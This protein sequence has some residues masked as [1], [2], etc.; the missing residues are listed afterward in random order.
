MKK[1]NFLI[2]WSLLILAFLTVGYIV[3][4][5]AGL[6][7]GSLFGIGVADDGTHLAQ[8]VIY[9]VFGSV[10]VTS[11]SLTQ[12][13][14]LKN[15]KIKISKWWILAGILGIIISEAVAGII[16]WQLKINR[17]DLG[18]FQGGPQLP[19]ALIFSFSGLLIGVFQWLVIRKQFTNSV[20]WIPANFLGWGLGHLVMFNLLAFFPGALLLGIITG[21][22]M[23]WILKSNRITV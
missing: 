23:Y 1:Y 15:Y 11:I 16:L 8:T 14:I 20:Y 17:S 6:T 13:Q 19:E 12:L 9:C 10:V 4:Y 18:V 22:F 5:I 2:N 21:L 7:T 3:G